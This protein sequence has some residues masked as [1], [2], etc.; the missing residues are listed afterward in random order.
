MTMSEKILAKASNKSS[1]EAG[2]IVMANIDVAMTHD[3]TGPLSVESFEKIG[4]E[5]V[6]DPSKI[7][8]PFDHQVPADSLDAA[9][10]HIIMREFVKKQ[11]IKNFYDV[12]EGVCHQILPE[13]G[14]VVPGEVIVGTD[15]HTC[16]HGALGAFA[17]G[18]GSTDMAMVFSTGQLWFK[19]P[20]TIR[21]NIEGTLKKNVYAKDV[22]LNIIG[23]VGA[24]GATY[25]ACEFAGSTVSN[26]TVSDRMVL[27]NMAIEMGGKTGLV[28]PDEK[29][30][31]YVKARSNK[32]YEV[33]KT[34]L[35]SS[36][37]EIMDID[38]DNLEP[39]VACPHNV[40]NVKP[41]SEVGVEIDQVFLGSCTNGRISDLRQA[42]KILKGNKIANGVRML[43]IP[44]SKEVY[45]KALNEG[46]IS[47][48]VDSGALVCNPC[49]GPCL[50]GHV[51]L[52]G[53]GEVSL[54]TSNRN[55]KGRQ[56]SP[57]GKVYLSSAAVA[58]ASAIKGRIVAPE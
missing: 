31:N 4:T 10:N 19:V 13:L 21:F 45:T 55:F 17:T 16:T 30:L 25:K 7:V 58:A 41:V 20:E 24:D 1:C 34:D 22:I 56:G 8:I 12:N 23:H 35:D 39:Q 38:V 57:E 28:E 2:E 3:L 50:G 43:V 14:H 49:C 32:P 33:F 51:G 54:S 5:K 42:A 40:D 15:S 52:I 36:S 26:M 48:F 27:C 29:T 18:I 47:T 53:P 9:N 37:L 11:G 46:L 44:A 6:W